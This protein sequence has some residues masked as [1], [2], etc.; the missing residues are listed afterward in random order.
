MGSEMC[1]RDRVRSVRPSDML[2]PDE[3]RG[4]MMPVSVI[5]GEADRVLR[6]EHRAFFEE[7]LPAHAEI[8]RLEEYGHVPHMT[9]PD[10][11]ARRVLQTV[12]AAVEWTR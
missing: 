4:L 5:W 2:S 7:H 11:L 12:R 1:I 10:E 3:L 8:H 6:P 9:H